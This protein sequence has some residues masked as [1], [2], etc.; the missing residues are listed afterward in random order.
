MNAT[1]DSEATNSLTKKEQALKQDKLQTSKKEATEQ[2][3]P[4]TTTGRRR[5]RQSKDIDPDIKRQR[6]LE[7]NRAA[8]SRYIRYF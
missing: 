8:A 5:G 3:Q 6:F 1:V 2:Q 7:R 4:T